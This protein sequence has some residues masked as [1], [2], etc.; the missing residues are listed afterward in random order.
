MKQAAP[1]ETESLATGAASTRTR[2]LLLLRTLA[3][4][5]NTDFVC[6]TVIQAAPHDIIKLRALE[7][8]WIE[9]FC[10]TQ[11]LLNRD[12]GLDIPLI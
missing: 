3:N 4:I 12:D 10:A 11:H 1:Y 7:R 6:V 8:S 9:R 2:T 5:H